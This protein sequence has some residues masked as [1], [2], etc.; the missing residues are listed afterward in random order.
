MSAFHELKFKN[1]PYR[2]SHCKCIQMKITGFYSKCQLSTNRKHKIDGQKVLLI[3]K[4]T[5]ESINFF[6]K[7]ICHFLKNFLKKFQKFLPPARKVVDLRKTWSFQW[8]PS[9]WWRLF[10]WTE[11]SR[12]RWKTGVLRIHC[13]R[14]GYSCLWCDSLECH[15]DSRTSSRNRCSPHRNSFGIVSRTAP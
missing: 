5:S 10:P 2:I 4:I 15:N 14:P 12:I 9:L 6:N 7:N 3:Q 1:F 8:N 13:F 11:N